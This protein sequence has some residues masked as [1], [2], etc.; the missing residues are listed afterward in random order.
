MDEDL[1]NKDTENM[2]ISNNFSKDIMEDY[3]GV[4]LHTMV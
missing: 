3:L 1:T 2:I 4:H